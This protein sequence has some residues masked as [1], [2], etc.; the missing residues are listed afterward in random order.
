MVQIAPMKNGQLIGYW[1][2]A[3]A[4]LPA[5]AKITVPPGTP[6]QTKVT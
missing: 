2:P 6:R 3:S 5:V 1:W 4:N